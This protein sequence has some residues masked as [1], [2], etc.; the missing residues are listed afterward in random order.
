[1]P[2]QGASDFCLIFEHSCNGC[3]SAPNSTTAAAEL[4]IGLSD[5]IRFLGGRN[6][7]VERRQAHDKLF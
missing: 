1:M 2:L 7:L 6:F 4:I 5:Y 3:G